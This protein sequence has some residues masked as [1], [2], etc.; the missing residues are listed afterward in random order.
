MRT[1]LYL[2]PLH[3]H[4]YDVQMQYRCHLLRDES[5]NLCGG[6]AK[7]KL[8]VRTYVHRSHLRCTLLCK[9]LHALCAHTH[10]NRSGVRVP[11]RNGAACKAARDADVRM[12]TLCAARACKYLLL[13]S[14]CQWMSHRIGNATM[15]IKPCP[16]FSLAPKPCGSK[17]PARCFPALADKRASQDHA[18]RGGLPDVSSS[19]DAG[20]DICSFML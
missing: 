6:C 11:T 8:S 15:R 12:P 13:P 7:E 9:H 18:V 5:A 10:P 14:V 16:C 17:Q 20:K 19:P 2:H 4:T 3:F 1:A